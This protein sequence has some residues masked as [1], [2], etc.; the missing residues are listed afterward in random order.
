[1]K[2]PARK[3]PTFNPNKPFSQAML[4]VSK[5][6]TTT[7]KKGAKTGKNGRILQNEG[8]FI[9]RNTMSSVMNPFSFDKNK[10]AEAATN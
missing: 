10:A 5:V 9:R 7:D 2:I 1:M 3:M 8:S 4:T 6:G